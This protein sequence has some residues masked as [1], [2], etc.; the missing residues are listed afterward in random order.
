MDELRPAPHPIKGDEL[1]AVLEETAFLTPR[2]TVGALNARG[3][4]TPYG[5]LWDMVLVKVWRK[6]FGIKSGV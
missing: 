1:R 6:R 4:L 3:L 2:E 5:K